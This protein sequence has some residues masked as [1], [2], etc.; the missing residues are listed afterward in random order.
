MKQ[1]ALTDI[2]YSFRKKKTKRAA[3]LEIMDEN[4]PWDEWVGVIEPIYPRE[5]RGR[6]PMGM[7]KTLHYC[8]I[9]SCFTL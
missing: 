3:F 8:V 7:E 4:I 9:F 5:K 1:D 6:P 2:D